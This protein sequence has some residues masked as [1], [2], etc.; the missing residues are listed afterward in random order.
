MR[1]LDPIIGGRSVL[2]YFTAEQFAVYSNA[3][4]AHGAT[5]NGD[6]FNGKE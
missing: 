5:K 1:G 4:L 2:L 6:G 3:I